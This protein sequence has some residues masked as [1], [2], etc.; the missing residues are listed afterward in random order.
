MLGLV[1][2]LVNGMLAVITVG[3]Q[4]FAIQGAGIGCGLAIIGAGI[5]IGLIGG[6]GVEA[7]ARQPEAANRIFSYMIIAAAL[8]EGVTLF[9]LLICFLALWWAR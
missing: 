5:G 2:G 6:K 7:V 3:G 9:A 8:V 1:N 4:G